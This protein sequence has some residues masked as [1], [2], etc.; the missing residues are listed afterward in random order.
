VFGG[1]SML[2]DLQEVLMLN[3]VTCPDCEQNISPR[4]Q[5]CPHCGAPPEIKMPD[6]PETKPI[7]IELTFYTVFLIIGGLPLVFMYHYKETPFGSIPAKDVIS[8]LMIITL[9]SIYWSYN[10]FL[11]NDKTLINNPKVKTRDTIV[12]LYLVAALVI[13]LFFTG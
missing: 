12:S 7:N 9:P 8:L 6:N 1:I 3:L 13:Y 2:I 5:F 4:A 11:F 10:K